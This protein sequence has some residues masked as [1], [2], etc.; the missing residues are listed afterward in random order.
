MALLKIVD[1][2]CARLLGLIS[3]IRQPL[4][5]IRNTKTE[6]TKVSLCIHAR[7]TLSTYYTSSCFEQSN[8][9]AT[10][11]D[12]FVHTF[13]CNNVLRLFHYQKVYSLH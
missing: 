6:L 4:L 7:Y 12:K 9:A 3:T 13:T 2:R 10:I 8:L 1:T 11:F 5:R